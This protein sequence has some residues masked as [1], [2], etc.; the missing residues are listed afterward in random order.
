[1][2]LR[3]NWSDPGQRIA[4]AGP[5]LRHCGGRQVTHSINRGAKFLKDESRNKSAGDGSA[6]WGKEDFSQ[7]FFVGVGAVEDGDVGKFRQFPDVQRGA[8]TYAGQD[9]RH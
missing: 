2:G 6:V 3:G 8:G 5:C 9:I 7:L 1:M 4:G